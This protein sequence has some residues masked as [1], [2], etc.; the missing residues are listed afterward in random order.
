MKL[1]ILILFAAILLPATSFAQA[2]RSYVNYRYAGVVPGK[3]LPNGVKHLGGGMI[4]DFEAET[5]YGVSQ[6][7]RGRTKMLWLEA[8]TGKDSGGITGWR[9]LDVLSFPGLTRADHLLFADDPAV[10]CR[11]SGKDIPNLVGVG[12]INMRRGTFTPSRL[13]V[14][15]LKSLK[16]VP[17]KL[18]GISCIFSAP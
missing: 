15:D 4:G 14:A 16:F 1:H 10:L 3:T 8:S 7:Q 13:W 5:V 9:V 2:S 6:V 12:R 11:R 18:R 17:L